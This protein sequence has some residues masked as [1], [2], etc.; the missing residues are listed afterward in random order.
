VVPGIRPGGADEV[1]VVRS[2]SSSSVSGYFRLAF[3]GSGRSP[4]IAHD[5]NAATFQRALENLPTVGVVAVEVANINAQAGRDW[6]V[7]FSTNV[8]DVPKMQVDY[9]FVDGDNA[10][11][12]V[13]DG[14]NAIDANGAA[15]AR[16]A[17]RATATARRCST[18]RPTRTRSPASRPRSATARASWP[19]TTAASASRS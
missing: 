13:F 6:R 10:L 11:V 2:R 5:A 8:G 14:D 3:D 15:S 17:R 7:T 9:A 19:R 18:A 4:Y 1:Q 16:S 12:E